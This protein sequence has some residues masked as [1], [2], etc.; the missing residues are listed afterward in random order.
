MT[1]A[2]IEIINDEFGT[3]I[4]RLCNGFYYIINKQGKKERFRANWAQTQL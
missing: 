4:Q 3:A 2:R 1:Q